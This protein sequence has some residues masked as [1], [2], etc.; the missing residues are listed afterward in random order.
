MEEVSVL[1]EELETLLIE[2]VP[3]LEVVVPLLDADDP[4]RL[5]VEE[6]AYMELPL[7][8]VK[9]P[10]PLVDPLDMA[11]DR[12]AWLCCAGHVLPC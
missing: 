6:V 3:A 9:G 8:V 2:E 11:A 10:A 7:L 4:D 1:A 5:L 12:P